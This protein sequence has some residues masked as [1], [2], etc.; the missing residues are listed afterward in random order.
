MSVGIMQS[1]PDTFC[2]AKWD[3]LYVS[4]EHNYAYSCC[5]STPTVFREQV[6]EFVSKERI[7]M[8]NGIQD[9]S[10]SYCWAVEH[11]GGE[12]L[13]H[14]HLKTF[15]TTTFEHYKNAPAP[16]QIQVTVGNECNFQC[17]YCNPKF[18][19]RWEHDVRKAEYRVFSDRYFWGID[20]KHEAVMENNIAF[21]K[22]FD[23]VERLSVIGGEPL[24]NKRTFELIDSVTADVLQ[25][26]TNLSCK[27]SVLDKLFERCSQY[28]SVVLVVS[29]D[30]TGSIAEFTR[31]G[32]DFAEFDSNFKYL[33]KNRPANLKVVV[34]SLM[35]SITV[36]DF[37]KFSQYMKQFLTTP[38]FEWRVE[39]CKHPVTQ[40]MATLPDRFKEQILVAIDAMT[41]Y[42]IWGLDTLATVVSKTAFNKN[43]HQQLNYFMHE[44]AKRKNI[45]IPLCLD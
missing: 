34:N 21:L 33:L 32:L 16:K 23:H 37:E 29:I 14:R 20:R 18:S 25:M 24:L 15:D 1:I 31:H 11:A 36:R 4:F 27:Q 44:F 12:S 8:L 39:Y 30:A 19:S 28:R 41:S 2:P 6:L 45:E 26:I 3:E 10:C 7:N 17:T 5:K 35:T 13:R 40:S 38:N 9:A 22:S 43:M 42:N